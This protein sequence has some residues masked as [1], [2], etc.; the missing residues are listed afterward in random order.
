[1]YTR[2]LHDHDENH[3]AVSARLPGPEPPASQY[4]A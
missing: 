3:A 2:R 1:M 4:S